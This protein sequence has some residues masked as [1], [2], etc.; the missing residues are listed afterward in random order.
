M[1][2]GLHTLTQ[3]RTKELLVIV[4]SRACRESRGRDSG[5]DLTNVQYKPTL[6]CHN[7]PYLYN[8]YIFI[9]NNE[10]NVKSKKLKLEV[11]LN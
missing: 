9:K 5:G 4:L 1:V 3:N 11:W 7:E 8:K 10:K 6:N 2:Y